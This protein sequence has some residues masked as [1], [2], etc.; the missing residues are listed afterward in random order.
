MCQE[1][2]GR[3]VK[4]CY[5]GVMKELVGVRVEPELKELLKKLADEENRNLSNFIVNA[6]IA[7]LKDYKGIEDWKKVR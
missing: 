3:F 6:I 7:Y 1:G 4:F 2:I 5:T